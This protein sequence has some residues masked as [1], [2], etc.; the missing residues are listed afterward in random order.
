MRPP[1]LRLDLRTQYQ[2]QTRHFSCFSSAGFF[3]FL[4]FE[5]VNKKNCFD[6]GTIFGA[7]IQTV[8]FMKVHILC[9]HDYERQNF[10]IFWVRMHF[11]DNIDFILWRTITYVILSMSSIYVDRTELCFCTSQN[12]LRGQKLSYRFF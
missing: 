7:K 3:L 9:L 5:F 12:L 6:L 1:R 11:R 4:F 10:R 2:G 8:L